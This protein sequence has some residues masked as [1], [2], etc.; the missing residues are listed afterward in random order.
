MKLWFS[1]LFHSE[2]PELAGA[3]EGNCWCVHSQPPPPSYHMVFQYFPMCFRGV[4]GFQSFFPAQC[5][6]RVMQ[7]TF[8]ARDACSSHVTVTKLWY[9]MLI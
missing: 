6:I 7:C 9:N 5:S 4:T 2:A 8:N 3:D 1:N